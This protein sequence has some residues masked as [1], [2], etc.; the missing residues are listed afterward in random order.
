MPFNEHCA[1]L[2]QFC[3]NLHMSLKQKNFSIQ[4]DTSHPNAKQLFVVFFYVTEKNI[5]NI[6]LISLEKSAGTSS[7]KRKKQVN[8]QRIPRLVAFTFQHEAGSLNIFKEKLHR[9]SPKI[10]RSEHF[11]DL[12]ETIFTVRESEIHDRP[13]AVA[14]R[15][16]SKVAFE[17]PPF[18]L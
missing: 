12:A 2:V 9:A 1:S 10:T 3:A 4:S 14:P 17:S 16:H 11:R 6:I 7:K 8:V 13:S 15:T 18:V 5:A